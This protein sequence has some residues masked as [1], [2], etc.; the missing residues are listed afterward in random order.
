MATPAPSQEPPDFILAM[1]GPLKRAFSRSHTTIPVPQLLRRQAAISVL[2]CWVPLALLSLVQGHFMGGIG[3]SFIRDIVT[4]VRFLVAL[5][6]LILA[7]MIVDQRIRP[8]MRRFAQR[9]VVPPDELP[10]FYAAINTAVRIYN[11]TIAEIALLVLVFTA[12]LWVWRHQIAANI[13][14]WYASSHEG[15]MHLT[16]AGYWLAFISIPV[17]QFI[18]L[19][20]Y[21][22]VLI[23]LWFLFRVSRLKLHLPPLHPDRAGGLGFIGKS[24]VAFA[25]LLFAHSALF[26]GQIESSIL[27]SGRSLISSE[28]SIIGYVIFSVAMALAPL[29][30][31]TPQLLRAKR[32]GLGKYGNFASCFVMDFDAKWMQSEAQIEPTLANDDIQSLADL[33]NSFAI[34]RE[35]HLVPIATDDIILLFGVTIAPFLP[36]LLTI[37][38]INQ[39]LHRALEIVF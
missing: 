36:L 18:L 33:S 7:E 22:Q 19:R 24:S 35:M 5:P 27:Y 28:M 30:A 12:G 10:K 39:L 26:A 2:V 17:F 20:W 34:A 31:F 14:S 1:G 6:V 4:H 37:M 8:I 29:F 21:M 25:P 38:P 16:M 9:H 23:W 11:S 15:P 13:A 32:D 3:L